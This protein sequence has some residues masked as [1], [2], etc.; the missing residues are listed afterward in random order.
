[1]EQEVLG[2]VG[3]SADMLEITNDVLSQQGYA[4][5]INID[6]DQ[7]IARGQCSTIADVITCVTVL[8]DIG[9]FSEIRIDEV[10]VVDAGDGSEQEVSF[11][12]IMTR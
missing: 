12:L 6:G 7:V 3:H 5:S 4:I 2:L 9:Y 1:M 11:T 8:Q 10:K